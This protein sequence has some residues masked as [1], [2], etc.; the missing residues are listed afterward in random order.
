MNTEAIKDLL[1]RMAD[2]ETI[3]AHRHSEWTGLGPI[4]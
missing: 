1:T 2:D 3:L 4:L